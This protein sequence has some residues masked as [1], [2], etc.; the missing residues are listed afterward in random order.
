MDKDECNNM[1]IDIPEKNDELKY[2]IRKADNSNLR[3]QQNPN[4]QT[5]H[6]NQQINYNNIL[7]NGLMVT[8]CYKYKNSDYTSESEKE[9]EERQKKKYA[10]IFYF[11]K[12]RK[13]NSKNYI[14][15]QYIENMEKMALLKWENEIMKYYCIKEPVEG[16]FG[17]ITETCRQHYDYKELEKLLI[18]DIEHEHKTNEDNNNIPDWINYLENQNLYCA[19]FQE[20]PYKVFREN[21]FTYCACFPNNI[22]K[23]KWHLEWALTK[24]L[25]DLCLILF[26]FFKDQCIYYNRCGKTPS[27]ENFCHFLNNYI[28]LFIN[29]IFKIK[30]HTLIWNIRDFEPIKI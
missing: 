12:N 26:D 20:T 14:H 18:H 30:N 6:G 3:L 23:R 9:E 21:R 15:D 10:G 17:L 25:H 24:E 1:D 13:E 29:G 11:K 8:N 27:H 19:Y 5:T 2:G 28:M 4:S 16:C 22:W 7:N